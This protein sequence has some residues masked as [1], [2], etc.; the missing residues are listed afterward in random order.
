MCYF[1]VKQACQVKLRGKPMHEQKE[2]LR[3]IDEL[4]ATTS[5]SEYN[6]LYRVTYSK[7]CDQYSA[8]AYYFEQQWN[9]G[10][11]FNQWK[12]HCCLPGVATTN[13]T[14][15]SFNAMFKRS[16]TNHT[17]H[18]MTALYD[19]IHDRLLVDLSERSSMVASYFTS[20]ESQTEQRLS[21]Q[22]LFVLTNITFT[23]VECLCNLLTNRQ[24][25]PITSM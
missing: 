6:D 23:I 1:H 13:S 2:V 10:S 4:H 17:R 12:V 15:E 8:F 19:I 3:D 21:K 25:H 11:A 14:L 24:E 18:T 22:M 16:Y 5:T 7:W 9:L 20:P